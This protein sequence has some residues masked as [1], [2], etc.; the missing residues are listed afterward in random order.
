VGG[1]WLVVVESRGMMGQ[2]LATGGC[3]TLQLLVI[4]R[5]IINKYVNSI[6]N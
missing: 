4:G 6:I 3:Q 1:C 5:L 2:C